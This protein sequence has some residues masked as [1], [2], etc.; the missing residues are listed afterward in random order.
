VRI[1]EFLR[2]GIYANL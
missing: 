1:L 2:N